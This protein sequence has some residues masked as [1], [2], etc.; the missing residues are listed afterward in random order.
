MKKHL[1][2]LYNSKLND[3][4][5]VRQRFAATQMAGPFLISPSEKYSKQPK[6]LLIVGQETKGWG[7]HV[8][9]VGEQMAVYERFNVGQT[10]YSS[11]FWNITRKIEILLGNDPYSCA[12]SNIS[13]FDVEGGRAKGDYEIVISTLDN[14][15]LD[16]IRILKPEVCL[17]YTGPTFD[18]RI[19]NVF[20]NVEFL[21]LEN[22]SIRQFSQLKHSDLPAL[23]FR[24]YHPNFMRRSHMEDNFLKTIANLSA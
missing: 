7:H 23:T 15:L 20:K 8:D 3:F 24:C 2:D 4:M 10:Y 12:W 19:K 5:S 14:I 21:P 22:Y 17:F 16:E 6:P 13:K 9:D 18:Y 1:F 11:P